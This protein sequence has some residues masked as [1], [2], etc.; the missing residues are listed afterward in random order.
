MWSDGAGYLNLKLITNGTL[1]RLLTHLSGL[2]FIQVSSFPGTPL[3]VGLVP[4]VSLNHE[5][6]LGDTLISGFDPQGVS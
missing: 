5:L 2:V 6:F 3:L 4:R 1:S